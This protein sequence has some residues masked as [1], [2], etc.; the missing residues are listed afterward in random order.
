M[1]GGEEP[2]VEPSAS[3]TTEEPTARW[4]RSQRGR[5]EWVVKPWCTSDGGAEATGGWCMCPSLRWQQ[6]SQPSDLGRHRG[7]YMPEAGGDKKQHG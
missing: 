6:R 7:S 1:E 5:R 2:G 3:A 4:S